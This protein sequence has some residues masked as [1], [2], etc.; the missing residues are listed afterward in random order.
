MQYWAYTRDRGWFVR[1]RRMS[2]S[3]CPDCGGGPLYRKPDRWIDRRLSFIERRFQCE[4]PGCLWEGHLPVERGAT[5]QN[6][7]AMSTNQSYFGIIVSALKSWGAQRGM[8]G[9]KVAPMRADANT[10][11]GAPLNAMRALDHAS[12]N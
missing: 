4:S 3:P 5:L 12:F 8:S 9:R 6:E 1:N 10:Q 11:D 2:S 7:Q